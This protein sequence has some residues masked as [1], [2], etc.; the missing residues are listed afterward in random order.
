MIFYVTSIYL[1]IYFI[2][3]TLLC[4][5]VHVNVEI[6]SQFCVII[7]LLL[8]KNFVTKPFLSISAK[9]KSTPELIDLM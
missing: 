3:Q 4:I 8:T 6:L 2:T 7:I 9:D 1:H 5:S